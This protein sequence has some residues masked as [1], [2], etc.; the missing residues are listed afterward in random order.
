MIY[1]MGLRKA[2]PHWYIWIVPV[3]I[4]SKLAARIGKEE[5]CP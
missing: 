4:V 1:Q 5:H 2:Q 3:L